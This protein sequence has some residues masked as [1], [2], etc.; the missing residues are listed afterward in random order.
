M[1]K[2]NLKHIKPLS[3]AENVELWVKCSFWLFFFFTC[4]SVHLART[5]WHTVSLS[6]KGAFEEEY[7]PQLL[8]SS[9][10]SSV[11]LCEIDWGFSVKRRPLGEKGAHYIEREAENKR[12]RRKR[13]Q[14]ALPPPSL[15]FFPGAQTIKRLSECYL[16]KKGRNHLMT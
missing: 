1:A 5:A 7:F 2:R 16:F 6:T 12:A 10:E 13:R 9:G 14:C 4:Q 11:I 8:S 15:I 3:K